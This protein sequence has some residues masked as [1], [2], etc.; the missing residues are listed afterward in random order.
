MICPR[1]SE[2]QELAQ[3]D[4]SNELVL[5][6]APLWPDREPS[7]G[8]N[9]EPVDTIICAAPVTG[10]ATIRPANV[11][12]PGVK[13][14]FACIHHRP[15][16]AAMKRL[17]E[18]REAGKLRTI[19]LPYLGQDN[20]RLNHRLDPAAQ[21]AF[22]PLAQAALKAAGVRTFNTAGG[23]VVAIEGAPPPKNAVINEWDSL[24]QATAFTIEGVE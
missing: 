17:F 22:T 2:V 11:S 8:L 19:I 24:E 15:Q 4:R 21:A 13:S 23:K 10:C 18:L 6:L 5:G 14:V 12:S 16:N 3:S 20:S 9:V 7:I 1:R